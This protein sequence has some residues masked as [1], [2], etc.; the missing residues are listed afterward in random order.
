MEYVCFLLPLLLLNNLVVFKVFQRCVS[1]CFLGISFLLAEGCV[2]D[3]E[4]LASYAGYERRAKSVWP[5]TA[6][7]DGD[8]RLRVLDPSVQEAFGL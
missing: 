3:L 6:A 2:K 5:V 8:G 4:M 1:S 7:Q